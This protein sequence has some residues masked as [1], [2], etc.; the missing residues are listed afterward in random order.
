MVRALSARKTWVEMK[1][2][3]QY[4]GVFGASLHRL[5]DVNHLVGIHTRRIALLAMNYG[6]EHSVQLS[7]R[8]LNTYLRAT[9]NGRDVRSAYNLLNEYRLLTEQALA[10]SRH[11]DV[12]TLANHFRFYGQLAF[13]SQLAFVLEIVAYDL[14]TVLEQAHTHNAPC[15]D[16]LLTL[17]LDLDREPEGAGSQE[18]SL[19]GVRKAQVKLAT[20]YL[21]HGAVDNARRIYEDM[22]SEKVD[23]LKSI[24]DELQAVK[25][26]EYWEVVDR[27]INFD[28]LDEARRAQ[29]ATFF[30]WFPW[31]AG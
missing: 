11:D 19:R 28:Y 26:V 29:L 21:V 13:K 23:R 24:R 16:A 4:Q 27:G 14:C 5:R 8:F 20:F 25:D 6:D 31:S 15:H 9:I 22:R 7:I 18:S 30:G 1:I 10:A 17:F 2:L 3:R 12:D